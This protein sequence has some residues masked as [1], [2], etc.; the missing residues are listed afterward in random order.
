MDKQAK[1]ALKGTRRGKGRALRSQAAR[2][3]ERASATTGPSENLG[4]LAQG[5]GKARLIVEN[6]ACGD[7]ENKKTASATGLVQVESSPNFNNSV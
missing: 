6:E 4:S 5:G 2:K 3:E 1:K 7:G